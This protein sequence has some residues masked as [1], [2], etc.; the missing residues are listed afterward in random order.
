MAF[1]T[2]SNSL[3]IIRSNDFNESGE[4]EGEI[5]KKPISLFSRRERTELLGFRYLLETPESFFGK[6]YVPIITEDKFFYVFEGN[7]P[8]YHIDVKCERLHSKYQNYKI[9]EG[10]RGDKDK[11]VEFRKWFKANADLLERNDNWFHLK[12]KLA[13]GDSVTLE[14]IDHKNSG[15]VIAENLD[16]HELEMAVDDLINQAFDYYREAPVAKQKIIQ[17]FE[18][19]TFL[20]YTNKPIY[21]NNTTY[22][23]EVIK[24]FLKKYHEKFKRPMQELLKEYYRV[25]YNPNLEFQGHLLDQLGFVACK[26]CCHDVMG[27]NVVKTK[28]SGK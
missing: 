4:L 18:Q 8:A 12:L 20:A 7:K 26:Q 21:N 11:V 16:L 22:T 27:E 25:K 5:Y 24:K 14:E 13:F 10:I 28:N 9:P 23:D 15:A 17:R 3:R 6:Y 1:L 19:H 2:K